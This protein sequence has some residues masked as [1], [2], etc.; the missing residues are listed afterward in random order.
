MPFWEISFRVI[1]TEYWV[2]EL[3]PGLFIIEG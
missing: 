1:A 2:R 3:V